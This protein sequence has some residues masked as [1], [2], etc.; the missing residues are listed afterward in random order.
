[1]TA[2]IFVGIAFIGTL[3]NIARNPACWWIWLV[4]NS[5]FLWIAFRAGD[6]PHTVLFI[7]L[8][9][10]SVAGWFSWRRYEC[11]SPKYRMKK[12]G[13]RWTGQR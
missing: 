3:F 7:L 8:S 2:W 5:G 10:S 4:S 12:G 13:G 11:R 9:L 6:W 1:M